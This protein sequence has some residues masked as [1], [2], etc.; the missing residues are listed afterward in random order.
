MTATASARRQSVS[1]V[2]WGCLGF[3][4]LAALPAGG[5]WPMFRRDAARSGLA[6]GAA[7]GDLQVVWSAELGGSVD[8]SPAVVGGVVYVGNS[9]GGVHALTAVDGSDVWSFD[10]GGAVVSSPAVAEGLVVFGSV[11][12]FVYALDAATGEPT[13]RFRTYGPIISSPAVVDGTGVVGSM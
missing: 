3:C 5:D 1:R 8:S 12:R 4:L 6:P 9:L 13:W 2:I 11:D 10:T 7:V